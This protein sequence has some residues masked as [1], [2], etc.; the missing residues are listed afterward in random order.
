M[1]RILLSAVVLCI[2]LLTACEGDPREESST[3]VVKLA[4]GEPPGADGAGI[5]LMVQATVASDVGEDFSITL[6]A[7]GGAMIDPVTG[8][9]STQIC[10]EGID[11][12]QAVLFEPA[13]GVGDCRVIGRLWNGSCGG[14][15]AILLSTSL[16][17]DP[18]DVGQEAAESDTSDSSTSDNATDSSTSDSGTGESSTGDSSTGDSST[19]DSTTGG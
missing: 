15:T 13:Q 9:T 3:L 11:G 14:R 12:A 6:D 17:F 1:R 2:S 10:L 8:D 19:S 16:L 5:V 7:L 18:E 4:E